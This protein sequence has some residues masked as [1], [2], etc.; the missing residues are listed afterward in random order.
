MFDSD[1]NAA[2]LSHFFFGRSDWPLLLSC[3]ACLW[4]KVPDAEGDLLK[5][6]GSDAMESF[7]RSW[8]LRDGIVPHPSVMVK[9]Y[10]AKQS[11]KVARRMKRKAD[12]MSPS[13]AT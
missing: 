12:M 8:P 10:R 9:A 4:E 13:E 7:A 11:P 3:F 1:I 5:Q 2:A 6:V